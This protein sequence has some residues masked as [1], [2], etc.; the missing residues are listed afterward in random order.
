MKR[1]KSCNNHSCAPRIYRKTPNITGDYDLDA[2][3][4]HG[5]HSPA[6]QSK[7]ET[8]IDTM[9]TIYGPRGYDNYSG[10]SGD[11]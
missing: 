4:M 8:H 10:Y 9:H 11:D 7:L 3:I 6:M 1:P 2:S 5:K